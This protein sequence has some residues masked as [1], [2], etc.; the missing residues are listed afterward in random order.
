MIPSWVLDT[1]VVVSGLR[2]ARGLSGRLIDGVVAGHL[3]I[4]YDDRI[5][6]EYCEVLSRPRFLITPVRLHAFLDLLRI[7]DHVTVGS[8]KG[9]PPIDPDDQPF[10]EVALRATGKILVTGN[11]KHYPPSC[12]EEVAVL[13]PRE[14]WARFIWKTEAP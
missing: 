4:T 9:Q 3:R 6:S 7:Q 11:I 2:S 10:L 5:E 12:R 13:T 14:A 8:W 1:N